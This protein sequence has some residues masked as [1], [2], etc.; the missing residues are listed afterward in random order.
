MI[1]ANKT[2]DFARKFQVKTFENLDDNQIK[3]LRTNPN[4]VAY[5][6]LQQND[7]LVATKPSTMSKLEYQFSART[8]APRLESPITPERSSFISSLSTATYDLTNSNEINMFSI[9]KFERKFQQYIEE[10]FQVKLTHKRERNNLTLELTGSR[11]TD[12]DNAIRDIKQLF[13]LLSTKKF[14]ESISK[15]SFVI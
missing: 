13:S 7:Y 10:T 15:N 8:T 5:D 12:L 1:F 3:I 2:N 11:K 14:T 9:E 4:L 6:R